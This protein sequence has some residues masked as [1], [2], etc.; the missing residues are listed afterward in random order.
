MIRIKVFPLKKIL[1]RIEIILAY[2]SFVTIITILFLLVFTQKND[3]TKEVFSNKL[4]TKVEINKTNHINNILKNKIRIF[5]YIDFDDYAE[6]NEQ[7]LIIENNYTENIVNN[8]IRNEIIVDMQESEKWNRSEKYNNVLIMENGKIKVD[9]V[10]ISNYSKLSLNLEELKNP[11]KYTITNESNFLLFHTHTSET[12]K[13]IESEYSDYYR[14]QNE[15]YNMISVGKA[16]QSSLISK[17]YKC[18]H[19]KTVHDYPSYNGA[20]KAALKTVEECLKKENHD[21]LID[22]HRDAISSNE[23]FRPTVEVNGKSAA[24]LMFV[25]GTNAAGLSHDNWMENLKL[26]IMIQNRAEEMY[27]GLFREL[28]L[29]SSRYNQQVSDGALILEVG[30]TGNTLEEA[31]NAMKFFSNV[32]DSLNVEKM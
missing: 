15:N 13:I 6:E 14:T 30:A 18:N 29:S 21:L 16:L 20:Y 26:A 23:N 8:D 19:V 28:H 7:N 2:F 10:V 11:S 32:I 17:G 3:I 5:N 4:L 27:P 1:Y 9:N 22:I 24:K 31:Q 25:V 12:Y